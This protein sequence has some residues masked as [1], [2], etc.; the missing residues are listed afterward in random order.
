ME[1]LS[2]AF[3]GVYGSILVYM[4][5]ACVITGKTSQMGGSYS[6][7]IRATQFNPQGDYRRYVNLQTKT[8]YVPEVDKS[9]RIVVSAQGIRTINKKGPFKALMEV[10]IIT[11][12]H[13]Q[14]AKRKTVLNKVAA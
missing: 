2:L 6:N 9:F 1:S 4:A 7:R 13:I 14:Q 12:A 10:G 8:F 5:K 3:D 11:L